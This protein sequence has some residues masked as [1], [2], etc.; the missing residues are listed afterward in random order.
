M[1]AMGWMSKPTGLENNVTPGYK[2]KITL[3]AHHT[4]RMAVTH[5]TPNTNLVSSGRCDGK[6]MVC[7]YMTTHFSLSS[8]LGPI[9]PALCRLPGLPMLGPDGCLPEYRLPD[10]PA[11][12]ARPL[13][14]VW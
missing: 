14:F 9:A 12:G 4:M 2:Q 6:K 7:V 5:K 8:P 1:L 11:P 13:L 10:G 3:S